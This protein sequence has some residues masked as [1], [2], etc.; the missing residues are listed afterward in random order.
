VTTNSPPDAPGARDHVE[1]VVAEDDV[2]R[3]ARARGAELGCRS[4]APGV[5]AALRFLAAATQ[6]RAVVEV[7]IGAGVSGLCLLGGMAPDGVLTSI[8]VEPENLRLARRAFGDAGLPVART[9]LITGR[10]LDVLPRLADGAYDLVFVDGARTEYP[11]HLEH[12]VR[13]LRPGGVVVFDNAL[14]D[15]RVPDPGQRDPESTAVREVIR[16]VR[17]DDRLVPLLLPLGDGLLAAAKLP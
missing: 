13:L 4:V 2:L 1:Q 15:G 6:A 9:R 14:R 10:P 3:A 8:D 11:K 7:G 17:D 12:G 5:G 16:T